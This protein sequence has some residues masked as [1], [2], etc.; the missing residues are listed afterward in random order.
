VHST[1]KLFAVALAGSLGALVLPVGAVRADTSPSLPVAKT[2]LPLTGFYRLVVD[3]ARDRL[4]FSQGGID[5]DGAVGYGTGG[6]VVTNL[7]GRKV[8]TIDDGK[9]VLGISLSP[10]GGTLYAAV[11]SERAVIAINTASLRVTATYPL[12]AD[13]YPWDVTVQSGRV[14]VSYDVGTGPSWHA[15]IGDIDPSTARP[16][17]KNQP[18]MGGWYSAPE[19]AADPRNSGALVAASGSLPAAVASYDVVAGR[20]TV[21]SRSAR[22]DNCENQID[23]AVTPGGKGFIL[24][25][26]WPYGDYEYSTANLRQQWDYPSARFPWAV[27]IAPNGTV[28]AGEYDTMHEP[29]LYLYQSGAG[30]PLAT[31]QFEVA[32]PGGHYS[33]DIAERGLAWSADGSRLYVVLLQAT[34][35]AA[36]PTPRTRCASSPF[37]R[38]RPPSR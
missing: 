6:V 28:A 1:R 34:P 7:S 32:G 11:R 21:Q 20:V 2:T 23:L 30:N 24:A 38:S 13:D 9:A 29:D 26:G 15:G 27:A 19:I 31:E 35:A 37:P 22:F 33:P 4:L 17:F 14:W 10:N 36:S 12:P 16:V 3:T 5:A 18:A 8:T 25:C